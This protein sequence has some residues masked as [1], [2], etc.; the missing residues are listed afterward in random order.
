MVA[1]PPW[2]TPLLTQQK[3][4]AGCRH[5]FSRALRSCRVR[6]S[7]TGGQQG[8]ELTGDFKNK[9]KRKRKKKSFYCIFV[10]HTNALLYI[11]FFIPWCW[12]ISAV[13]WLK[14]KNIRLFF[15]HFC[16]LALGEKKKRKKKPTKEKKLKKKKQNKNQQNTWLSMLSLLIECDCPRTCTESCFQ[17]YE[18]S[19]ETK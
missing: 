17:E 15:I 2:R 10:I 18:D 14:N 4:F 11:I 16:F 5:W 8:R 1:G 13:T 19:L 6:G 9:K 12:I 3:A 7:R